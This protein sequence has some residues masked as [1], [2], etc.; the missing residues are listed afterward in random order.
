MVIVENLFYMNRSFFHFWGYF[1]VFLIL[2]LES[3][4]FLGAFIPGGTILLLLAGLLTRFGFF[5]LW[6]VLLVAFSASIAIDFFGYMCGRQVDRDFLHKYTKY[7]LVSRD[8]LERV[9]RIVHGHT[10]KSLILGRLNPV[11]RAIAPFLVGVENVKFYK[12]LIWNVIGGAL[13][14]TLFIFLGYLFGG[15]LAIAKVAELYILGGTILIAGGF[16]IYY[17]ISMLRRNTDK[18]KC[19]FNR[20]GDNSKK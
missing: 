10:G 4:P 3:L 6:K 5:S 13:W 17:I 16:Y 8:T 14:V 12:F 7:L 11:T 20:N 1:F 19:I 18:I 2:F 15:S 9:G